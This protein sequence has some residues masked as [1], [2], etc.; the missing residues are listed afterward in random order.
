MSTPNP[1]TVEWVPLA[2]GGGPPGA[3]GPQGPE[4]PQGAQGPAGAPSTVPGPAGTAG[5][6]WIYGTGNP[7]G[8]SD[9]VGTLYLDGANGN[10]WE[11]Q[12]GGW[13]FTGISIK[14]AQGIQGNPG[15]AGT[16]GAQGPAGPTN[17]W[18]MGQTWAI[19]GA[20]SAGGLPGI[21]VPKLASQT[22]TLK[23]VRA[24]ILSGTSIV[25]Q[26]RRNGSNLGGAITITTTAATTAFNQALANGDGIDFVLST[27]TGSPADLSLTAFLEH[28]A[29]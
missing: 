12:A 20:L 21:F 11:K 18:Q 26:C 28:L 2:A 15:T 5:D 25:A 4:G 24:N 17:P 1:A 16:A 7:S 22:I 3:T 19:L 9:R 27:P 13:V 8:G 29:A 23:G 10:I 14:G 6:E